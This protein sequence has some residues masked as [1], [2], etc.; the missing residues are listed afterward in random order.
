[1]RVKEDA[2]SFEESSLIQRFIYGRRQ[3]LVHVTDPAK[4]H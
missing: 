4:L 1:M 3:W 2:K